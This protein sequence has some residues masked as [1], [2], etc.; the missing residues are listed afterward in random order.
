VA[1]TRREQLQV[2]FVDFWPNF[3][4][5]DNVIT[6]ALNDSFDLVFS[7]DPEVVFF[8]CFGQEHLNFRCQRALLLWENRAWGFD[9][10]DL[11]ITCDEVAHDRHFRLPLWAARYNEIKGQIAPVG[12]DAAHRSRFAAV[13]VSN[14]GAPTRNR[15]HDLLESYRPVASGGRFRNNVD[16]PVPDKIE[17]LRTAKFSIAAENSSYPGYCTEKLVDGLFANTIPVYWGNPNVS[18]EF[19]PQRFVNVHEFRSLDDVLDRIIE[20]D[21]DDEQY[22]TVLSAPWFVGPPPVCTDL[23]AFSTWLASGISSRRRPV[24]QR[25]GAALLVPRVWNRLKMRHRVRTRVR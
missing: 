22:M 8:S 2:A 24:A 19:N 18:S 20:L 12:P 21:T 3:D 10:T 14:A 6:R 23:E 5:R 9:T 7:D 16:G 4:A 11:A 13:V 25:S 1:S 15:I 17:F